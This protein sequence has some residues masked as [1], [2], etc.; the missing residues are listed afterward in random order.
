[1]GRNR[2]D[3][4][5][6]VLFSFL[7]V[8]L[9]LANYHFLVRPKGYLN[10]DFMDLWTG[11]RALIEGV[12]PYSP[13][14]WIP[15]K[16]R[17]GSSWMPNLRAPHPFWTLMIFVPL[18]FMP[19][20]YAAAF[21]LA[22]SDIFLG[23][24]VFLIARFLTDGRPSF[25]EL[26]ILLIGA[27][28]F[29]GVVVTFTNGQLSLFLLF[30]IGFFL[31]LF[32]QEK[33]FLAGFALALLLL[34]PSPFILFI[35]LVGLW[36][37]VHRN[38]KVIFGGLTGFIALFVP[39]WL[40]QPGWLFE[41]LAVRS[42]TAV[43]F[44]TPTVWGLAYNITSEWWVLLGLCITVLLTAG[45]GWLIVSRR[46]VSVIEISILALSGSLFVTPY[47]WAYDHALLLL[48]LAFLF[49]ELKRGWMKYAIWFFLSTFLPWLLFV[50][51]LKKGNDALS[52]ML[53]LIIGS[54]CLFLIFR[55]DWI[56]FISPSAHPH[57]L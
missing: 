48:P 50:L 19:T 30:I 4:K 13:D 46:E 56:V 54:L 17:L 42:K 49:L 23:A 51:A 18:A 28:T 32:K 31:F 45:L 57:R 5:T 12:D 36:L 44:H 34:K 47:I 14:I 16:T 53:P 21:W 29:R 1:V 9:I 38:W 27:L 43:T 41:W 2:F 10:E 33:L 3:L 52:S 20:N 25:T 15:L 26:I 39:S 22:I 6:A 11:G 8:F 55:K 40:V 7:L 24:S 35:P 37:I